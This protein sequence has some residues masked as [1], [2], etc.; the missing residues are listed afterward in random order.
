[1]QAQGPLKGRSVLGRLGGFLKLGVP[2]GVPVI[3][4]IVFKGILGSPWETTNLGLR[5]YL[6]FSCSGVMG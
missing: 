2:F 3:G 6:R 1:M 4:A 5:A